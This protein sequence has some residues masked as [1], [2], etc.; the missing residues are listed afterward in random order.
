M[1]KQLATW[2]LALAV[3]GCGAGPVRAQTPGVSVRTEGAGWLSG[4]PLQTQ[5]LLG[6][7]GETYVGVWIEVPDV[8]R[9]SARP[10]MAVSLVVDTS[11]SMAGPKIEHARLAAAGLLES[12]RDGD[13]V[14]VYGF[15]NAVTQYAP[16]TVVSSHT[17]ASLMQRVQSLYANGGTFL[18]GGLHQAVMRM[19]EAP[20]SHPLRRVFLISDGRANVGP[21]D[22]GSLGQLA[23]SATEWGTQVTAIGVGTDYDQSTLSA[24]AVRSSGRLYHLGRPEAM[25]QILDRELNL[26]ASSA[27][28]NAE[29]EIR[30]APGVVILSNHTTGASLDN[31]VVRLPLGALFGGQRREILLRVRVPARRPGALPV[32]I[33]QLVYQEP[34]GER[35][36]EQETTIQVRVTRSPAAAARSEEPRVASMVANAQATEAQLRAAQ[37][38]R[39]GRA[40][41]AA[42]ELAQ[43]E[44]V[45]TRQAEA[46]PASPSAD[47]LRG[48]AAQIAG[49]R[50]RAQTA[51]SAAAARE[52]SYDV[53]DQAFEAEG[54]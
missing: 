41:D 43:A 53:A 13:L 17:R 21:S 31:G 7:D 5:V 51:T 28:V 46:A 26:L 2:A 49:Q 23:A 19:G 47:A 8:R 27:A 39:D 4:S 16:P 32:V 15:N 50:R 52:E 1:T 54:Y 22:P 3:S 40:Q 30:P 45:L 10:P 29:L 12:L 14:S 6:Q 24:M 44:Q 9:T 35:R 38:L 34:D 25:A 42:R 20:A 36:R 37:H 33:A 18:Y 11:G 48:R